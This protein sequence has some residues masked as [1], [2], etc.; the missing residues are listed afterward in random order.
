MYIRALKILSVPLM[1]L[2]YQIL[3]FSPKILCKIKKKMYLCADKTHKYEQ[4]II[5]SII[6]YV[7]PALIGAG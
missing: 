6:H 7:L 1:I 4:T 5:D 3:V 2:F